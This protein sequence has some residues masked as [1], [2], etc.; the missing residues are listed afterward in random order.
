MITLVN[1]TATEELGKIIG[2]AAEPS[3]NLVLTG[4]LGAGKTT[5]TKGIAR[6][7]G[8]EQM[9]KSPTYTIIREYQQGRLPLY[10]MDVYRIEAGAGD[11][12]LDD[13]FEGDGLSVI[14]W[15]QQLGEYLPEDYLELLISK[16]EQDENLRQIELLAH[17]EQAQRFQTRIMKAWE[18]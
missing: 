12:G 1:T 17:G 6:G 15:G 16:D 14:E 13:Y 2:R 5:L 11:L 18:A 9:I 4:D 10:H 3:D 8:I 7:L